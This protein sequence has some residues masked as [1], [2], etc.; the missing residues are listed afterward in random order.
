MV[1]LRRRAQPLT[2]DLGGLARVCQRLFSQRRKQLGSILGRSTPLPAGVRP[3]QRP[4]ELTVEQWV[5]LAQVIA[6]AAGVT[7][8]PPASDES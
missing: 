3:E 5:A 7:R 8:N 4:E 1:V 6:P 2:S